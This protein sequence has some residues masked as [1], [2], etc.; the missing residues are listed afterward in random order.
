MKFN[1]GLFASAI[2]VVA[3]L[4]GDYLLYPVLFIET[5]KPLLA[6]VLIIFA[7]LAGLTLIVNIIAKIR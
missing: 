3:A 6:A 5:A 2:V 4:L 1:Y 7:G